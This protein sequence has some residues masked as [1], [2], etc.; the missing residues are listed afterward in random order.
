MTEESAKSTEDPG[1]KGGVMSPNSKRTFSEIRHAPVL[2]P[3]KQKIVLDEETFEDSFLRCVVCKERYN[4]TE[5]SPR[6]FPC[7]HTFCI[8]C[9]HLFYEKEAEYRQSLAPMAITAGSDMEFAVQIACPTCG[10]N[11]ITTAKG[12]GELTTDHRIVQLMDFVGHTDKQTITFCPNHA[13][14]PL[15]FFCEKCVQPICRDCTV[16]DHKECSKDGNVIDLCSASEK[17]TPVLDEG[18]NKMKKEAQELSEKKAECVKAL[19]KCKSGD[20]PLTKSIKESFEK[21]RKALND[22]EQE[23]LDMVTGSPVK[24]KQTVEEKHNKLVEKEKEVEKIIKDIEKV[25]FDGTVPEMFVVYKEVTEYKTESGIENEEIENSD[26]STS[27]F[28]KRDESLILNRIT[29]YGEIQTSPKS[30]GYSSTSGIGY[31]S[32]IG[33]GTSYL[34]TSSRY[35][36]SYTPSS[37]TSRYTPRTS[38]K[39]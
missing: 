7:H 36:P 6:L 30:N 25:K 15:N 10:K 17:Y 9:I 24:R 28:N 26:G 8:S 31:T 2:Q 3:P 12:M 21:L 33:S 37:Y 35:T 27:T 4:M 29:N 32:S 11:F 38:Y 19:E 13:L 1:F 39:Y 22:R 23:V 16:L 20:D 5:R 14:Q 34:G 18:V